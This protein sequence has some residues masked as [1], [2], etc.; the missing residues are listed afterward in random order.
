M[1]TVV[2]TGS[3]K[4]IGLATSLAFARAGYTVHATMR[5]PAA[6]PELAETAARE[7]LPI[8]VAQMDVV[9]DQSV[10]DAMAAIGKLGPVDVLINNA[11][12]ERSG[13]IEELPLSAFR[14]E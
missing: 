9:S 13:S 14:E 4:G 11:G 12:V 8:H 5:N 6:A 10:R 2:V 7:S 3:S 1:A